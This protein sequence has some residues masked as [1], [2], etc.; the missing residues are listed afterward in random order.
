M[1]FARVRSTEYQRDEGLHLFTETRVNGVFPFTKNKKGTFRIPFAL[2]HFCGLSFD[3][4][5]RNAHTW[6]GAAP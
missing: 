3:S 4:M 1:L 2:Y 5:C 6:Y